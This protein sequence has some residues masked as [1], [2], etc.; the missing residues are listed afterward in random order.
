MKDI[1]IHEHVFLRFNLYE[2]AKFQILI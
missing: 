1:S 2:M